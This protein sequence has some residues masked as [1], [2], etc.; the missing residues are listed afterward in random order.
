MPAAGNGT[1]SPQW[2]PRHASYWRGM[3]RGSRGERPKGVSMGDEKEKRRENLTPEQY[4]V[5]QEA[6]TER[7]F[8][9]EYLN[10]KE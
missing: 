7:P 10:H 8:T 3:I 9:G 6:A 4:K 5:T 2:Q 1:G